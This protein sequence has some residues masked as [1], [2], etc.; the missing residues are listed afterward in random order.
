MKSESKVK[1]AVGSL[2]RILAQQSVVSESIHHSI[3]AL[4][5]RQTGYES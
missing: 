4:G 1:E 5:F 3:E 2:Q